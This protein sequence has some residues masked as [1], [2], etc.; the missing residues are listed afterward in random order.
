[1]IEIKSPAEIAVMREAGRLV[2]NILQE[3]VKETAPGV[4]TKYLD[5]LAE[6]RCR[7]NGVKPAFKGYGGFPF[8]VCCS[9]NH[10]VVHG[11]PNTKPLKEGDI[12]SMDFGV[13]YKGFFGDS[14]LTVGVGQISSEAQ[15]LMTATKASLDAGIE[16]MRP[17]NRLG[18]V[19]H[20]VQVSAEA[21]GFSVVRQFVGHGIGRNLHEDPQLPNFGPAGRG[22]KL[23]PGMVIAIEP[24]INAGTWE[25]RVLDDGWTAVTLDGKLSAHFEH[26]VAVTED[27]P[28]ILS[29]P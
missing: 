11:F 7:E 5:E 1:M 18:D 16:M 9:L 24:M 12:L 8:S 20:A 13:V 6:R 27:G 25:V 3:L 2:A 22:V 29:L 10:R 23:K 15:A 4:T 26:T 19:S 17:G 14:A 21:A 28:Y